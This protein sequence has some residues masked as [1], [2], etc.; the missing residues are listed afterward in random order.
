MLSSDLATV[1][2]MDGRFSSMISLGLSKSS[3]MGDKSYSLTTLIWS[4]LDQF[5]LS[6]GMS[7]ME[8]ED[9][10]LI[11]LHSY[12][13]TFAYLNGTLMN[14]NGYTWIKP[15]PKF[16]SYGY[17]V[18]VITLFIKKPE[19]GYENSLTT[20]M[21]AFWTKPYPVSKKWITSPQIFLMNSPLSYNSITGETTI[22]KDISF[23]LGSSNDY[24]LTKR[25]GL[26]IAYKSMISLQ[27]EF[28]LLHNIQIGSKMT[29]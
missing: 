27:P 5:V 24:K 22:N 8:L 10:K 14:L 18:G 7:K 1:Q 28:K 16:G 20:S 23:L 12:S 11:A 19:G 21:V 4:T 15:N 26:N 6:G 17:N 13:T 3:L 9:G 25:F 29:F 2:G